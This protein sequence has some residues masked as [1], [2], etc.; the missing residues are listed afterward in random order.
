VKEQILE[1]NLIHEIKKA[2]KD[3]LD[4]LAPSHEILLENPFHKSPEV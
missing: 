3:Y 2:S 1:M 4:P